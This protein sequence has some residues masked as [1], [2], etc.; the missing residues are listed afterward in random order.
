MKILILTWTDP[1]P[2]GDSIKKAFEDKGCSVTEIK[3]RPSI[4]E[5][6]IVEKKVSETIEQIVPDLVF[7]MKGAGISS[8]HL[9]R[10]R[11]LCSAKF[12]LWMVDDPLIRWKK[13]WPPVL[14]EPTISSYPLYD[15]IFIYD[16]FYVQQLKHMGLDNVSFLPCCYDDRYFPIKTDSK[17]ELIFY[18]TNIIKRER[19][20]L[21][22]DDYNL[23]V[24]GIGWEDSVLDHRIIP[25]DAWN[26]SNLVYNQSKIVLNIHHPQSVNGANLRCFESMASGRMLITEPLKD[27][28]D[29]FI[30]DKEIVFYY[31]IQD[32]KEKVVYYLKNEDEREEIAKRGYQAVTKA[33]SLSHRTDTILKIF[34]SL[35]S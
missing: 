15:Q 25:V 19:I 34:R 31:N 7:V 22:L 10:F 29:M 3:Y 26:D 33:H 11:D 35:K 16:T 8:E 9:S 30:E 14:K 32:L 17:Y 28:K 4:K 2:P 1:M 18:G 27:L 20:L 24:A 5:F 13:E 21:E 23:R 12:F 6:Q